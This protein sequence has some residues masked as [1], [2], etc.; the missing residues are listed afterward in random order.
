MVVAPTAAR[1]RR[2][3]LNQSHPFSLRSRRGGGGG[4]DAEACPCAGRG[5]RGPPRCGAREPRSVIPAPPVIPA[6][7]RHS[8]PAPSFLR[9]QESRRSTQARTQRPTPTALNR[10]RD[11]PALCGGKCPVGTEAGRPVAEPGSP[12]PPIPAPLRHSR[13]APSFL[14]PPLRQAGIQAI[15]PS[16]HAATNPDGAEPPTRPRQMSRRDRAAPSEP[17]IPAPLRHSRPA[18]SPFLPRSVIPAEAGIQAIHPSPHAATNPD[19]AEPPTR[20]TRS[21]GGNVP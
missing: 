6:P 2:T 5:Q 20:P 18:P 9:R 3:P 15:H 12:A 8:R 19:G 10:P 13:P 4:G 11:P 17:F 1:P 21:A 7:L 16:P 14:P